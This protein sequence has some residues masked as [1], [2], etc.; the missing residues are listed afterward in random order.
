[1]EGF[2]WKKARGVNTSLINRRNW[3]R[4][5]F[6]IDG[7]F[8]TYYETFDQKKGV[9]VNKKGVIPLKDCG[10]L[11]VAHA[12]MQHC[13]VVRHEDRRPIYLNAESENEKFIW[14]E[15]I[16]KASKM[17][18][19]EVK[20][21]P[22]LT[23]YW[24]AL[25]LDPAANPTLKQIDRAYKKA[26]L[27]AHPDKGGDAD[28]FKAVTDAYEIITST[29][30]EEEEE[31]KYTHLTLKATIKKGPPGVG[32]GMVVVEDPKNGSIVVKEV[33]DGLKIV[34]KTDPEELEL[35]KGDVVIAIGDDDIR[36]WPLIRVVQRLNNF[37]VPIGGLV[38]LT[39]DR[40]VRVDGEE[41]RDEKPDFSEDQNPWDETEPVFVPPQPDGE[42]EEEPRETAKSIF[43]GPDEGYDEEATPIDPYPN[44]NSNGE[45]V[46]ATSRSR[47]ATMSRNVFKDDTESMAAKIQELTQTNEDLEIEMNEVKEKLAMA[48]AK[49]SGMRR[50]VEEANQTAQ[51]CNERAQHAEVEF[52]RVLLSTEEYHEARRQHHVAPEKRE[53]ATTTSKNLKEARDKAI[54]AVAATDPTGNMLRK[55][56]REGESA[57]DKLKRLEAR[58]AIKGLINLEQKGSAANKEALKMRQGDLQSRL[59]PNSRLNH[60]DLRSKGVIRGARSGMDESSAKIMKKRLNQKLKYRP[61]HSDLVKGGILRP[62]AK[63]R[64][65]GS[66]AV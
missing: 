18:E 5:W 30:D 45:S 58:L 37:R 19:G 33:L 26:A 12:K 66:R 8:M 49:L 9:P 47:A 7:Q 10:F 41:E 63:G 39:F 50:E 22:D 57:E 56:E 51:D 16:E 59:N 54:A 53:P 65:Y 61:N 28:M 48:E 6:V 64:A 14:L 2:L 15:A 42:Y 35:K 29:L 25:K 1:M 21:K 62:G 24:A 11:M 38:P 23:P 40:K 4:R 17:V 43:E 46:R 52:Q 36:S 55:W 34:G 20:G 44:E 13:W 3:K 31:K 32:F 60:S 27:R